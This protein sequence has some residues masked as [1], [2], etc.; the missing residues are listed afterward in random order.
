MEREHSPHLDPLLKKEWDYTPSPQ[1]SP[2]KGEED[3][4]KGFS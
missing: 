2:L 1:S 3:Q 4:G